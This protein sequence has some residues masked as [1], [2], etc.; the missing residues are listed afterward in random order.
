M[1][2]HNERGKEGEAMAFKLLKEKGYQI[3][4]AN[5]RFGKNELDIIAMYKELLVIVEV[6]TRSNPYF[7]TP[8]EAVTIKKQR[9]IIR[10]A[11]AYVTEH[12]IENETRFD[13]VSVLF[14]NNKVEIEHIEDAFYPLVK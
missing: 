9:N 7:E 8:S 1:A 11:N 10:A 5:W 13:I 14:W 3:L 12:D 6:K 2:E 4:D